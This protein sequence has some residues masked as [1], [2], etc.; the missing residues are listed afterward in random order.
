MINKILLIF[1]ITFFS[2]SCGFQPI[3]TSKNINIAIDNIEKENKP[4]NNEIVSALK[5][6]FSE[7]N[8][9]TKINLKLDSNKSLVIK[10][11]DKKGNPSI[12]EIQIYVN[13]IVVI[14]EQ[15]TI[16]KSFAEKT[17][18]NNDNDKFKLSQY[19]RELEKI[20]TKKLIENIVNFLSNVS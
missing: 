12:Y 8:S 14:N 17:S 15:K 6:I 20:L 19:Q 2:T 11:K 3:Y 5:N 13:L 10:S 18:F 9:T 7:N 1:F 4:I 16:N